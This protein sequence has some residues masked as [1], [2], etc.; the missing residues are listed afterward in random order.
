MTKLLNSTLQANFLL[1]RR[2][3]LVLTVQTMCTYVFLNDQIFN[4]FHNK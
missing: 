4:A 3:L 2:T 1:I